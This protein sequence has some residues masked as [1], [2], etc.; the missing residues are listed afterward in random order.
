M[1]KRKPANLSRNLRD[2][3]RGGTTS[4]EELQKQLPSVAELEEQLQDG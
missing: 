1:A 3:S 2:K 4:S